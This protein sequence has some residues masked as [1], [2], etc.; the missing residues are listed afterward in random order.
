[1]TVHILCFGILKEICGD[2]SF[3]VEIPEG[4]TVEFVLKGLCERHPGLSRLRESI[5]VAGNQ[6][7]LDRPHTIHA[8]DEVAFLPPVSGGVS[9]ATFHVALTREK[10]IPANLSEALA[11][12]AD[13]AVCTFEGVV[14]NHSRG[15]ETLFLDYEAYEPM[16]LRQIREIAQR[17]QADFGIHGVALVHRLGRLQVGE[18][19]VFVGVAAAHRAEAFAACRWLIDTLKATVPI[20]KKEHFADGAEWAAEEPFPELVAQ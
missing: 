11:T 8:G 17:A 2:E 3:A 18:C 9:V 16:A 14:R 5:A 7:Y 4:A 10:I 20:W 13:G 12:E 6:Q 19:S 15:R 1:M